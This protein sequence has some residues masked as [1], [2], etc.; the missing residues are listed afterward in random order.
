MAFRWGD[1]D[2]G[3]SAESIA[4][5][6]SDGADEGLRY[7]IGRFAPAPRLSV[8]ERERAI[9]HIADLPAGLA[10]AVHGLGPAQ[11][12]S[13]YRPGGWTIRQLVHHVTDSHINSYVRFKWAMTEPRPVIK[14][15]DEKAWAALADARIAP[16]EPSLQLLAVLHQRWTGWLR[17]LTEEDWRVELIHPESGPT[18]LDAMLQ[19]YSWHSMHHLAHVTSWRDRLPQ[20]ETR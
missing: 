15:Y 17:S 2:M 7:P 3:S 11:L 8:T 5:G 16:I 6:R 18:S 12:D 4:G 20:G 10:A 14:A 19:Y 13:P 9:Q 1:R